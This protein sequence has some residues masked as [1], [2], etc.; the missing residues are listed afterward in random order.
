MPHR[1][2]LDESKEPQE[3]KIMFHHGAEITVEWS[4]DLTLTLALTLNP[5]LRLNVNDLQ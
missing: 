3:V 2:I 4:V 1:N 5:N